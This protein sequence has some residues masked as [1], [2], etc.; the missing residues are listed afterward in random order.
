M[1]PVAPAFDR[2]QLPNGRSLIGQPGQQLAN[3]A[4]AS[5]AVALHP[6]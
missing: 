5:N 6:I 2:F 4:T 1:V 3:S